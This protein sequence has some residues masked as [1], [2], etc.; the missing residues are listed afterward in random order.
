[1]S[2]ETQSSSLYSLTSQRKFTLIELLVVIAIISVLAAMLLPALSKAREKARSTNCISNLRQLGMACLF[3]ADDYEDYL[4]PSQWTSNYTWR[5]Y[6]ERIIYPTQNGFK[7]GPIFSCPSFAQWYSPKDNAGNG[8]S[9]GYNATCYQAG[10]MT[11]ANAHRFGTVRKITRIA[12]PTER[13]LLADFYALGRAD[14]KN[15]PYFGYGD[16]VNDETNLTFS[17]I[18]RHT[19]KGNICAPAGNVFNIKA[20]ALNFPVKRVELNYDEW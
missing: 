16:F 12:R 17:R 3:Y 6:L 13:P 14:Q 7:G 18:N 2:K 4:P 11:A 1:M 20:N 10:T 5:Y 9:Y 15:Q 19:R 8:T